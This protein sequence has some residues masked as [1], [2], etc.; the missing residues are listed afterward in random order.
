MTSPSEA[1]A[2]QF[3]VQLTRLS[4]IP[5]CATLFRETIAPHGFDTFACGEVDIVDRDRTAFYIIDWPDRWRAFYLASNMIERD[6]LLDELPLRREP[7]TWSDLRRDR[8]LSRAGRE[9]LD[10]VAANGWSEGLVVSLPRGAGRFGL[11]SLV[12]DRGELDLKTRAFL[13]LISICLHTHVRA[14]IPT[15]EFAAPP[16]GLTAREM[17]SLKLVARGFSDRRIAAALGIAQSTAH[18]HVENAKRKLKTR[19]RAETIAVAASL[20]IV[21][22]WPGRAPPP[23]A[24]NGSNRTHGRTGSPERWPAE[25]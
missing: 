25:S 12:G 16:A 11:I 17:E 8:K 1:D 20:G 7:F 5:S 3:N 9:A 18:E 4:D 22:A 19:S 14:L 15:G 13:C 24:I 6:P 10:L 23:G 21:E 2:F